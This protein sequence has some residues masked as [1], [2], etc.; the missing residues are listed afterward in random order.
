MSANSRYEDWNRRREVGDTNS[1]VGTVRHGRT[2]LLRPSLTDSDSDGAHLTFPTPDSTPDAENDASPT[3][4]TLLNTHLVPEGR[5]SHVRG[6]GLH[7][8]TPPLTPPPSSANSQSTS[9]EGSPAIC[10]FNSIQEVT[11]RAIQETESPPENLRPRL[12]QRDNLQ[13]FLDLLNQGK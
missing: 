13:S 7:A 10:R 8:D 4:L 5:V 9:T 3:V 2:D 1:E 12:L 11:G 6:Q